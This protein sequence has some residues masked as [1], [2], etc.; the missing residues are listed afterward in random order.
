MY[1]IFFVILQAKLIYNEKSYFIWTG[2]SALPISA[3]KWLNFKMIL[4]FRGDVT[5]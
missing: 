4:T 2:T 3:F 1:A 5:N